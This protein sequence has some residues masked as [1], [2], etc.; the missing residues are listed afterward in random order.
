[1]S[2]FTVF[3]SWNTIVNQ[4]R[5]EAVKQIKTLFGVLKD[6]NP[7]KEDWAS[8]PTA[9]W[10]E[11]QRKAELIKAKPSKCHSSMQMKD[12]AS[13]S[14]IDWAQY[15]N[16]GVKVQERKVHRGPGSSCCSR[17]FM[18]GPWAEFSNRFSNLIAALRTEAQDV[19]KSSFLNSLPTLF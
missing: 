19:H 10:R 11:E 12:S 3:N 5:F 9:H 14:R 15:A 13:L 4:Y 17:M 6:L 18:A 1:M 7:N 16:E 2:P 8:N